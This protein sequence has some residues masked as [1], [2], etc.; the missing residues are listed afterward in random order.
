[1]KKIRKKFSKINFKTF[2]L[3]IL[4][5]VMLNLLLVNS[6]KKT[7]EERGAIVIATNSSS[8]NLSF[9]AFG[10]MHD[11]VLVARTM[12]GSTDRISF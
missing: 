11:V 8:V 12:K 4:A 6:G 5:D 10:F 1:M 3:R 2:F 9:N 7:E